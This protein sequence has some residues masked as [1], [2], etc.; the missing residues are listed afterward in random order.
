[1]PSLCVSETSR[2]DALFIGTAFLDIVFAE[3]DGPP[4]AGREVWAAKRIFSPGGMANNAIGAAR[5]GLHSAL[6]TAIGEDSCG[7]LLWAALEGEPGLDLSWARRVRGIETALTV[8]VSDDLD[9]SLISHGLLDPLNVAEITRT[10]PFATTSFASL[11]PEPVEWLAL[12][13]RAGSVV[14]AGVGWDKRHGWSQDMISQLSDVDVFVAN[15]EEALAYT[16]ASSVQDALRRL[17]EHVALVVVTLGGRGVIALDAATGLEVSVDAVP[18]PVRD[19]TGAGDE[20]VAGL[21]YAT[22]VASLPLVDRLRFAA[23]CSGLAVRGWGGSASAPTLAVINSWSR[24]AEPRPHGYAFL[25][26]LLTAS[27][28]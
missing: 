6:V 17:G 5:L 23:L 28:I 9:R 24:S 10:L 8:A 13:R 15:E 16:R 1:M 2:V 26:E 7:D 27:T 14:F 11:H 21:M 20:F 18:G 3:L 12:L 22:T 19:T 4:A 25:D